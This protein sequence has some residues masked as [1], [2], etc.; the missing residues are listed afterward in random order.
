MGILLTTLLIVL[1][2][3]VIPLSFVVIMFEGE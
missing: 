3:G 1:L 2:L